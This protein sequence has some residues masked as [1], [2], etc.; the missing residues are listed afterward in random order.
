MSG[1]CHSWPRIF[2]FK[3]VFST[4]LGM[5]SRRRWS[6]LF[7]AFFFFFV[8][9][10]HHANVACTIPQKKRCTLN[11]P[12]QRPSPA[13]SQPT[14]SSLWPE[15]RH[16]IISTGAG[17]K[18]NYCTNLLDTSSPYTPATSSLSLPAASPIPPCAVFCQLKLPNCHLVASL[19]AFFICW[20]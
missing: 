15:L 16:V 8:R 3:Y 12:L 7:V 10:S 19:L 1:Y 14:L 9:C 20:F 18:N 5:C 17:T 6:T 2:L 4:W 13:L 11:D